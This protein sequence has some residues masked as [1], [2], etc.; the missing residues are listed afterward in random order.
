MVQ[1]GIRHH[2]VT[3]KWPQANGK[4]EGQNSS[5]LKRLQIASAEKKTWKTELNIYLAAYRALPHPTTDVSPAELLFGRKIRTK[6]TEP[7]DVHVEQVL[8]WLKEGCKTLRSTSS[9]SGTSTTG[10]KG[11]LSTRSNPTPYTVVSKHGNSLIL[12]SKKEPNTTTTLRMLRSCY[13]TMRCQAC[14]KEQYQK[15]VE[16]SRNQFNSRVCHRNQMW[17]RPKFKLKDT[18]LPNL[19]FYSGDCRG[20]AWHQFISRINYTRLWKTLTVLTEN[21]RDTIEYMSL[22]ETVYFFNVFL[23]LCLQ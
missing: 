14:R 9:R 21:I 12:Q 10:E 8:C 5:L 2:K 1:Q 19:R 18:Q 6:L 16:K 7:S 20:K 13:S 3:A 11:Q 17:L 22:N 4:V 15:Q 23:A